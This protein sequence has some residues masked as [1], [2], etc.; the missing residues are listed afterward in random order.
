[1]PKVTKEQTSRREEEIICACK[2][3]Y[4][5]LS[6]KEITI[7]KI[8]E[9]TTFTRT[10][11]YNYF[12]TKEEIFLAILKGEYDKWTDDVAS[13]L[14]SGEGG[15]ENEFAAHLAKTLSM[16]PML[17]KILSMNL[18]DIECNYSIE[19]LTAF[20][21]SYGRSLAVMG[22]TLQKKLGFTKEAAEDFIYS[23]YPFIY[24]IYPY[25]SATQKQLAA[26]A[27]AGL[28]HK[29]ITVYDM[30]YACAVKLLSS[31]KN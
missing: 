16:R 8:A 23:F 1:M 7:K 24:G 30:T 20:K 25:T 12:Q 4:E 21:V 22:E 26:M 5:S 9:F 18:Y 31:Y 27:R 14:P 15:A 17:L 19:A 28:V 11:I 3:L 13:F 6:F 10:S 2:K 29:D